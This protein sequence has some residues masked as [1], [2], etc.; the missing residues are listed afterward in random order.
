M[1]NLSNIGTWDLIEELRSRGYYMK[2]V[3]GVP[4]VEAKLD[5][6]NS[7]RDEAEG[8]IIVLSHEDKVEIVNNA[9]STIKI[10]AIMEEDIEDEILDNY[11]N[12]DYYK[13]IE[14]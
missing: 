12:E 4:D 11:D 3:F 6:I 14:E 10:S 8:N 2:L 9:F 5:E 1:S 7:D 13:P